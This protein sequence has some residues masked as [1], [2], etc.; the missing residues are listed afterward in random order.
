MS[1]MARTP[2][3][4]TPLLFSERYA[5]AGDE[6]DAGE[7]AAAREGMPQTKRA[8][9]SPSMSPTSSVVLTSAPAPSLPAPPALAAPPAAPRVGLLYD[10][11]CLKHCDLG[12]RRRAERPERA[13]ACV[14]ALRGSGLAARMVAVEP[15]R[16]SD[17]ELA[18]VHSP[19]YLSLIHI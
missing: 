2:A 14:A 6:L 9:R 7:R 8:R 18:L 13:A 16:A 4:E 5:D 1:A 10:A 19:H 17:D 3:A 12:A 15:R 11:E